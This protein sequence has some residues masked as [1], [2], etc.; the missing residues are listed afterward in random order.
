MQCEGTLTGN[1][2]DFIYCLVIIGR[3]MRF[4]KSNSLRQQ[5]SEAFDTMDTNKNGTIELDELKT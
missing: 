3:I 1:K 2:I 5:V 4:I